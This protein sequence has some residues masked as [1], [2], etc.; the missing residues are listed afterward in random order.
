MGFQNFD[1]SFESFLIIGDNSWEW[2]EK[3]VTTLGKTYE[4]TTLHIITVIDKTQLSV[5]ING[6]KLTANIL[7]P[8]SMDG[9]KKSL[10]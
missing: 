5:Y 2:Q 4:N 6:I 7:L 3:G 1:L 9:K 8:V 10:P